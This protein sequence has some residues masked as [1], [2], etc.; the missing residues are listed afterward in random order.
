MKKRNT[1]IPP[2]CWSGWETRAEAPHPQ[3]LLGANRRGQEGH[4][5]FRCPAALWV[6]QQAGGGWAGR[7]RRAPPRQSAGAMLPPSGAAPAHPRAG[8]APASLRWPPQGTLR[9]GVWTQPLGPFPSEDHNHCD[10][11]QGGAVEQAC[12]AGGPC[13]WR[14]GRARRWG[15]GTDPAPAPAGPA[16]TDGWAVFVEKRVRAFWGPSTEQL[17]PP[18]VLPLVLWDSRCGGDTAGPTWWAPGAQRPG[19]WGM[20]DRGAGGLG[21]GQGQAPAFLEIGTGHPPEGRPCTRRCCPGPGTAHAPP[22][23]GGPTLPGAAQAT[24]PAVPRTCRAG[25][26]PAAAT[27][28]SG[29]CRRAPGGCWCSRRRTGASA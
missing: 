29:S 13:V 22:P 9:T 20:W 19:S 28:C 23:P 26:S 5:D 14:G 27:R 10:T 11:G 4:G 21:L 6:V 24:Q 8:W 17:V 15:L 2:V 7:A 18:W 16:E 1:Y 3:T 12:G 25:R